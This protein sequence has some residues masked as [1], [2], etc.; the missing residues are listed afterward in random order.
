MLQKSLKEL[1]ITANKLLSLEAFEVLDELLL[2][3]TV[4][5]SCLK[6]IALLKTV[7]TYKNY[8]SSYIEAL[9]NTRVSILAMG[10]DPTVLLKDL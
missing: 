4:H 7:S 2:N 3:I 1:V 8:L 6:S 5:G 10:S 9:D